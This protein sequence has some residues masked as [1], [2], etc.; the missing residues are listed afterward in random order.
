M[1]SICIP[2]YES[3]GKGVFF[4]SELIDTINNQTYK[5]FE[6]IISDHSLD[7]EIKNYVEKLSTDTKIIYHRN[8]EKRGNSSC[9][10][11][12][13]LELATGDF[14]KIMHIDDKFYNERALEIINDSINNSE[15]EVYWG[16]VGFNHLF[17]EEN[18]IDKF[19]TPSIV[20]NSSIGVYFMNGCPS[21]SFFKNNLG[22]QFDENLIIINDLDLHYRLMNEYGKPL[23]ISET[24]VTIR[25]HP[26]QVTNLLDEYTIKEMNEIN[27][28]K[29][30]IK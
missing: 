17:D 2:T 21:V 14:I 12:K 9:N 15:T 5:N 8:T 3:K 10:M 4:L 19:M 7:D 22:I 27:Y 29:N 28:F 13:G 6:I 26:N 11:N 23:I 25:M 24:L 20:H 16:G 18:K 1:I 30:K